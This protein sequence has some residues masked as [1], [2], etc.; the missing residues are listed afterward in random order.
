VPEPAGAPGRSARGSPPACSG[1]VP[2]DGLLSPH[3]GRD[4]RPACLA[5]A[6]ALG[7]EP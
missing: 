3:P 1:R 2:Q 6:P 7:P 5:R 4:L